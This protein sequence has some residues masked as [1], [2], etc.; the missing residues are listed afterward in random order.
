MKILY[1]YRLLE[2]YLS[3]FIQ[4]PENKEFNLIIVHYVDCFKEKY[5]IV[6]ST[7]N[8]KR[9]QMSLNNS[10]KNIKKQQILQDMSISLKMLKN[11]VDFSK[12]IRKKILQ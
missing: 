3:R 9:K 1:H 11:P 4:K 12:M 6:K 5:F 10:Y 7:L 2:K 8:L